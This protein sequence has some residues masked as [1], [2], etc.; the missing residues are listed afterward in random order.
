MHTEWKTGISAKSKHCAKG[1]SL[2]ESMCK[3]EKVGN[4]QVQRN[5]K[6]VRSVIM[7]KGRNCMS[8]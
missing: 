7:V 2:S 1:M 4:L 8:G 5:D 6:S 3:E